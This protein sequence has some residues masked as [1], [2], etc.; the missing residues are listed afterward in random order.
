M[1]TSY[2]RKFFI[3][4][5]DHCMFLNIKPKG[6]GKIMVKGI[7]GELELNIENCETEEDYKIFLIGRGNQKIVSPLLE[8][9]M[10]D[11]RGKGA[12]KLTFNLN[13]MGEEKI[14]IEKY[15]GIILKRGENILLTGYIVKDDGIIN[16]YIRNSSH[17]KAFPQEEIVKEPIEKEDKVPEISHIPENQ[18]NISEPEQPLQG[19]HEEQEIVEE[20]KIQDV[21][22]MVADSENQEPSDDTFEEQEM[23]Y[24]ERQQDM[25]YIKRVNYK[26]Q[27]TNYLLSI[28]RFFPNIK[29]FKLDL[30]GYEWWRIESGDPDMHR[31]FLPFYNYI[32]NMGNEYDFMGDTPNCKSMM[33]KYGHYIFGMYKESGEVKYYI[34]GIPG[35]FSAEEHPLRGVTGFNTW[36]EGESAIGY[37]LIYIDPMTGHVI[38]LLNP[39][40]PSN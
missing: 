15:S 23:K 34:Y 39:M 4:K 28:L 9:I 13:S 6:F 17:E 32:F 35:E 20:E 16:Q 7:K 11:E 19:L 37:W 31:G 40:V 18:E 14:S 1:G 24:K 36:F 12:A 8:R 25:E 33:K 3:L 21:E 2:M 30:K 10:T 5:D 22:N 26:S 29:P 38:R 27:M